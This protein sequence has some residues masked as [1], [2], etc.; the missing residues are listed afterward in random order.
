MKS[1]TYKVNAVQVKRSAAID[2]LYTKY[3]PPT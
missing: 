1:K 3:L 2:K